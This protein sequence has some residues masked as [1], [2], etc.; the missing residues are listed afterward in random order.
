MKLN[1]FGSSRRNL[2]ARLWAGFI[3]LF[4]SV[5]LLACQPS[6]EVLQPTPTT[7]QPVATVAPAAHAI[8]II[9]VD[10]D[11]PL[12]QAL[13]ALDRGLTLL[14]AVENRGFT[15]EPQVVVTARLYDP[16][17]ARVALLD[18]TVVAQDL[19]PGEVRVLRFPE[20]R[21]LPMRDRYELVVQVAEVAGEVV[22]EDNVRRYDIVV[23][24]RAR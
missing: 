13:M 24:D 14:V 12:D 6:I 3:L 20:V 19:E 22:G 18:E 2:S 7:L 10:F 8:A 9:G 16:T 4:T 21:A 17:G 1:V 11:P 23:Y 5:V 15:F